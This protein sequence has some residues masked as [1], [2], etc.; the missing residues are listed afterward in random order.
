MRACG[1]AHHVQHDAV[2]GGGLV[3]MKSA[4]RRRWVA[5]GPTVL[6]SNAAAAVEDVVVPLSVFD[7]PLPPPQPPRIN[8]AA[9]AA[10]IER[11][12]TLKEPTPGYGPL[13]SFT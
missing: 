13:G 2:T 8:V 5:P 1:Q 10:M 6:A 3:S 9:M 4:Q 7:D 11:R 12:V